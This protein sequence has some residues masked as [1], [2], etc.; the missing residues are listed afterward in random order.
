[1]TAFSSSSTKPAL[2]AAF[3]LK[4]GK[5]PTDSHDEFEEYLDEAFLLND[6]AHPPKTPIT[7]FNHANGT[8]VLTPPRSPLSL[9]WHSPG[10]PP[11]TASA[12]MSTP[13]W[14][15]YDVIG[16]MRSRERSD[17]THMTGSPISPMPRTS[18][19]VYLIELSPGRERGED[20]LEEEPPSTP[21]PQTTS[22]SDELTPEKDEGED[23]LLE[24]SPSTPAPR[25]TPTDGELTAEENEG[26][27]GPVDE[28]VE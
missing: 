27:A 2:A 8:A 4:L 7:R 16:R 11:P 1:M 23:G 20:G 19:T 22:T 6:V 17:P 18:P 5:A 13:L 14:S 25:S 9:L 10:M 24:E 26:D 15:M 12:M 21:A 3:D 28:V